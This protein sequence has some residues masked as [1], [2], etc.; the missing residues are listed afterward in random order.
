[1]ENILV[2]AC[3]LSVACRY[4]GK[5][6]SYDLKG[7]EEKYNLIPFCPEIYGGLPTPRIPS[8]IVCGH[9]MNKQGEDVTSEYMKGANEALNICRRLKITKALLKEKSPSCGSGVVYDGTFTHT[10]TNGDGVT[11]KLLKENGILV[12]G[13]NEI[14]ILKNME[15]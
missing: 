9:V 10:L 12:F 2:S 4:D 1:M 11:A 8:E 3:L 15:E 7:V 14:D 6:V 13:E 5:R